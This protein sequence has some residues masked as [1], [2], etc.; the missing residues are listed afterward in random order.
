MWATMPQQNMA[1]SERLKHNQRHFRRYCS[2]FPPSAGVIAGGKELAQE[3][4]ND[5]E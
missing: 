2:S 1:N 4:L 3:K 5:I